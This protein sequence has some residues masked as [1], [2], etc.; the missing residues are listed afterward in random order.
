MF[1]R[2]KEAIQISLPTHC[3]MSFMILI[4]ASPGILTCW[5]ALTYA[6]SVLTVTLAT[7]Q[8]GIVHLSLRELLTFLHW[9]L[10]VWWRLLYCIG[11]FHNQVTGT[12]KVMYTCEMFGRVCFKDR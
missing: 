1:D 10:F 12:Q 9:T 4:I 7:M 11:L 3:M 6:E 2:F 5:K 8:V